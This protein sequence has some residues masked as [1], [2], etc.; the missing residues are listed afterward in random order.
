MAR[1]LTRADFEK[2]VELA[3]ARRL[4]GGKD[5]GDEET[6]SN[7]G[8]EEA[9]D[10]SIGAAALLKMNKKRQI[11]AD[12]DEIFQSS[13]ASSS[14]SGGDRK[15]IAVVAKTEIKCQGTSNAHMWDVA[16]KLQSYFA[17]TKIHHD[18]EELGTVF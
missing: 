12:I 18:R 15:R 14:S 5:D 9:V 3:V 8:D 1:L 2:A 16:D 6:L 11:S 17:N 13:G 7:Q 4:A 10:E